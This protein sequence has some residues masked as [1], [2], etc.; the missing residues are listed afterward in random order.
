MLPMPSEE[1]PRFSYVTAEEV[2]GAEPR[3]VPGDVQGRKTVLSL[4][5]AISSLIQEVARR[6]GYGL[7]AVFHKRGAA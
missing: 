4:C 6:S 5:G 3:G 7:Y 1:F 2:R